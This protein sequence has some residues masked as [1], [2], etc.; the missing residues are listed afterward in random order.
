MIKPS[1]DEDE[2]RGSANGKKLVK[3]KPVE[4]PEAD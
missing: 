3:H 4:K 1:T 2:A